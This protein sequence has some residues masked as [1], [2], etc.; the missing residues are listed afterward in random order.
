MC[1]PF[2]FGQLPKRV[3]KC[4]PYPTLAQEIREMQLPDPPPRVTIRV[5]RV[6]FD[7]SDGTPTDVREEIS[8]E[9]QSRIFERDAS[10]AYL[11]ELGNEIA[12]VGVMGALQNQGYFRATATAKL[13]VLQS[14]ATEISVAAA[15]SA[16]PGPQYRVGDIRI[17][18]AD[19]RV[20]LEKSAEKLRDL[21]P[22]QRDEL[23]DVERIRAGLRN[24]T[25]AYGRRGYADM[26]VEPE[27][28][29]QDAHNTIDMVLKIDRQVQYR[30]GGIEFLGVNATTREKLVRSLPKPGDIYDGTRLREFLKVNQAILPTDASIDDVSVK[31]D[32]R[33]R[34]VAILFDF[35][36]CP[37]HSN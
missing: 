27:F 22:L 7:S 25:A 13:A 32:L 21:I 18:S 6:D 28:Q 33:S 16:S 20:P 11:N 29:I 9:L 4:L 10:T 36:T 1:V 26:T 2:A 31:H 5:A 23:F 30:V 35:R 3:E 12:E 17:E 37:P 8:T 19:D 24:L 34:T 14:S 15:I